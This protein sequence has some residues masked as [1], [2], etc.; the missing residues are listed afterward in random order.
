MPFPPR[1][2]LRRRP[3][4]RAGCLSLVA[5]WLVPV[6]ALARDTTVAAAANM[7]FALEEICAQFHADTG[8]ELRFVFGSSGNFAHQIEQGAPFELFISA[9]EALPLALADKGLTRDRGAVYAVGRL[10]LV[11]P[12]GSRLKADVTLSD[13]G[14]AAQDG[15]LTHFA[16][17]NPAH[18]PYGAR[19][20][21][22]LRRA[23]VWNALSSKLVLGEN[24]AQAAQ[25]V[26]SGNADGGLVA[27][28]IAL[29]PEV[30]SAATV[31]PLP[32]TLHAPLGQRMVLLKGAGDTARAFYDYLLQPKA[33][34][35]LQRHGYSL[36]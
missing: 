1:P 34:A 28:A 30:S 32:A 4:L 31:V 8:R 7:K 36:P 2:R 27:Y 11:V 3:R 25:F 13:V 17:A 18:A 19:A 10:A 14:A 21:E 5:A 24:V 6:A 33:Q 22:A 15:R 12:H 9:D 16:I 35:L 29:A 26:V 23:G 20:E